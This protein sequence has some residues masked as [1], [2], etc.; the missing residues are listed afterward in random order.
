MKNFIKFAIL[1]V[2]LGLSTTSC[3]DWLDV[4][5]DPNNPTSV[6][7]ELVLPVAQFY[8]AQIEQADRRLNTLGNLFMLNWSQA[9]GYSWYTDEFGY[10]VT[11]SFYAGIFNNTYSNAGKQ[12]AILRDLGEG[13]EYYQAIA[14]IMLSYHFQL[15]VDCYGDVPYTE[16]LG[17]SLE[18][19]PV[20]DD[21]QTIYE[22]LIV[23]LTDAIA[24]IKGAGAQI[25]EPG[26]DDANVR[27]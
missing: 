14:K 13:Y 21:A 10:N 18:A 6:T 5:T 25:A 19:T 12:Y 20:Y 16:A 7:P 27:R 3:E 2:V 1:L 22:D 9:D 17:R 26:E 4:N 11:S 8:S 15:L 24:L 23:Q